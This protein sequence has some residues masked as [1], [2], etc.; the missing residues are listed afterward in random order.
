MHTTSS[1]SQV[2]TPNRSTDMQSHSDP[3]ALADPH[4]TADMEMDLEAASGGGELTA[5]S[6]PSDA[7]YARHHQSTR[8]N[9]VCARYG[10]TWVLYSCSREYG[11][12]P[13]TAHVGPHWPCMLLT[14]AIAIAPA[15]L[16]LLYV[17]PAVALD[18]RL[19]YA[20]STDRCE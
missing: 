5:T 19:L 3:Q 18:M 16:V 17:A 10:R 15:F 7:A 11:Y 2:G 6:D 13:V 14:Y 12:F 20:Y 9:R 4:M 8:R 1:V